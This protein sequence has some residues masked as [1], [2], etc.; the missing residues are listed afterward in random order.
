MRYAH[1]SHAMNRQMPDQNTGERYSSQNPGAPKPSSDARSGTVTLLGHAVWLMTLS[2][3]H[4][5]WRI[6]DIERLVLPPIRLGQCRLYRNRKRVFAFATWAWLTE[7]AEEGYIS[8]TRLLQPEDWRAGRRLWII[9][10]IAPFGG[11]TK[12]GRDICANVFSDQQFRFIRR[13]TN[14]EIQS[15]RHWHGVNYDGPRAVREIRCGVRRSGPTPTAHA[16]SMKEDD[17]D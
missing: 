5:N 1:T 17:H 3:L 2:G 13:N 4:R 11:V 12:I 14:G 16:P 15:I 7:E 10:L 8:E 6:Q 9:D